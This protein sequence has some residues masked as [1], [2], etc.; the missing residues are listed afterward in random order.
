MLP[1]K[2]WSGKILFLA[3]AVLEKGGKNIPHI[4]EEEPSG[5]IL[6]MY[7]WPTN[8]LINICIQPGGALQ[9]LPTP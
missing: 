9:Q 7:I 2:Q 3:A 8:E 1:A 6:L 5:S 4:S